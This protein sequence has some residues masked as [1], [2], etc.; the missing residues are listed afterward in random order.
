MI[1][2]SRLSYHMDQKKVSISMVSAPPDSPLQS[3]SS[4][5]ALKTFV[6]SLQFLL[7]EPRDL[8]AQ[9]RALRRDEQYSNLLTVIPTR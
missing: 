5:Q 6:S 3:R 8:I 9:F 4:V 2:G 1:L 7:M